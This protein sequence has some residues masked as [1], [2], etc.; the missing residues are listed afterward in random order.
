MKKNISLLSASMFVNMGIGLI[1]PITTL[2]IHQDLAK[3]LVTSSYVLMAFSIFMVLGNLLGAQLFD[4][5]N[6]KLTSFLGAGIVLPS[7]ALLVVFPVWPLYVLLIISYGFG[8]G[9]LNSSINGYIAYKQK[10]DSNLFTNAYW[11][12]N[13]GMG[14]ST[15]LSGILFSV[16]IKIVFLG[17][18]LLFL[19]TFFIIWLFI[20]NIKIV[21]HLAQN[22][23]YRIPIRKNKKNF[24]YLMILCLSLIVIWI[25]YEQWNS[26]ISVYMLSKNNSVQQ[27]SF[28]FTISTI[29]IVV[30]QPIFNHFFRNTFENE[31]FR[32][33]LGILLFGISYLSI[34]GAGSYWRFV[35][36]ITLLSIG[37][38]LAL[39]TTPALL[40][41]FA[42]DYNR[43]SIQ[44][45]G[46][47]SASLGR[48]IGPLIGGAMITATDF[49]LTFILMFS[50]HFFVAILGTFLQN[51]QK[52]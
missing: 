30:I 9:I 5:W 40:N 20:P 36:G 3:S 31:K 49:T 15:F 47:T 33:L 25:G 45:V 6:P 38:M 32:M 21:H 42:T 48:A 46:G 4:R 19:L 14:I 13:L 27:Y 7:L 29:E 11:L 26:N 34:V 43:A 51:P 37:D 17:A 52:Q 24:F 35:F 18:F 16:S 2:Y 22:E 39:T 44:S 8:L 28:L 1:M 23:R 41:R 10:K 12:A 50:L